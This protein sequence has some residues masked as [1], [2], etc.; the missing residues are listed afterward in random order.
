M[1][2]L[3]PKFIWKPQ[4]GPQSWFITCPIKD[5]FFGGQR[6]GGKSDGLIGDWCYHNQ[7]WG[8]YSKGL[9]IRRTVGELNHFIERCREL[10]YDIAVYKDQKKIFVYHNGGTLRFSYLDRDIDADRYQGHEYTFLAIEEIEQF[11][12]SKPIDKL[13]ASL[14]SSKGVQTVFRATGNP[15]GVGHNWLKL[16]YIDPAPPLKP[17]TVTER[18]KDQV[19]TFERVFIPSRLEDNKILMKNDPDYEKNLLLAASGQQWLYDAW[20]FGSWDITAGGMFDDIW[21]RKIHV[22]KPFH[23]PRSWKVYRAFDW[24]S[25]KPF[26]VGWWAESDGTPAIWPD[27]QQ[28]YFASNSM[29]RIAEIYGWNGIA[30]E[31]VRMMD[32]DIARRIREKEQSIDH[33]ILDGPADNS[34]FDIDSRESNAGR[35]IADEYKQAP[36]KIKWQRSIK[37]R[38]PGWQKCRQMFT[39]SIKNPREEAG[40]YIFENCTQFI[41]TVPGLPRDDKKLDDLDTNSEDHIA[42]E[43]RYMMMFRKNKLIEKNLIGL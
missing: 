41:R 39:A 42:D 12:S 38:V 8:K 26:S 2:A 35:S 15:G 27:G 1:S 43:F 25:S 18:I 30:N 7:R 3:N 4:P 13:R 36:Y 34:I 14:R 23:I 24:G 32:K 6:G 20:R 19:V 21:N 22:L 9:I 29:F 40:V 17:F 10:F 28:R 5:I 16:R 11:P 37:T 31:G 33:V